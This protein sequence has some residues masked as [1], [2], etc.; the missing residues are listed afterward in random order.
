MPTVRRSRPG[1]GSRL[2]EIQ[3]AALAEPWPAVLE[4]ALADGPVLRVVETD[5]PVG[6]A[7]AL[8]TEDPLAY[9]PEIAV[10]PAEHGQGYGTALLRG[11]LAD[12]QAAG[13]ERVRLTARASDRRARQFYARRGFAVVDRVAEHFDAEDG[14]IYERRIGADQE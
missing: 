5:R 12:L 10:D 7:V 8:A 11:L 4:A 13:V 14:V 3:Q 1:D 9:V 6:Y 2:E